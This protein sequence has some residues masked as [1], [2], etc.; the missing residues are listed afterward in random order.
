MIAFVFLVAFWGCF[1]FCFCDFFCFSGCILGLLFFA[2]VIAFVF[3]V[4][5][6]GCFFVAFVLLFFSRCKTSR[7]KGSGRHKLRISTW[8]NSILKDLPGRRT[9]PLP[10]SI[11]F[12]SIGRKTAHSPRC[13]A[14][15]LRFVFLLQAPR[16][17]LCP[18]FPVGGDMV[19]G[20]VHGS[21]L[22][23]EIT[24]VF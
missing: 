1:F 17:T 19:K 11:L 16:K 4:A 12:Q 20:F 2:F 13:H 22:S 5:F 7:T 10:A 6:W 18:G 15:L 14:V 8:L 9:N 23:T 21:W 3:L 24:Q